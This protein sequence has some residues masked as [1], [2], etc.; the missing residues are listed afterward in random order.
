MATCEVFEFAL[1]ERCQTRLWFSEKASKELVRFLK[2][3]D[4]HKAFIKR[5]KRCSENGFLNFEAG[6]SPMVKPEWG[7]VYRFGILESLFR[8]IGFYEDASKQSFIVID[9]LVKRG[10]SLSKADRARIDEIAAIKKG[11]LWRKVTDEK[12]FPRLAR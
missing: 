6:E 5:L 9:T 1:A 3:S 4:P 10:Q 11:R 12:D 7:G 2:R 8:L